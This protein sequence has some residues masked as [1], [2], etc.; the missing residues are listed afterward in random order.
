MM[1]ERKNFMQ[2]VNKT[3]EGYLEPKPFESE[4]F[5]EKLGVRQFKKYMPTTGD[6]VTKNL[7]KWPDQVNKSTSVGDFKKARQWMKTT[8]LMHSVGF[9]TVLILDGVVVGMGEIAPALVV[10]ALNMVVNAYPIMVQRYNRLRINNILDK[11][12]KRQTN[13]VK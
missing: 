1:A 11:I 9:Y 12:E 10:G 2:A 13:L 6:W 5:Y 8:E 7:W 4:A 3:I